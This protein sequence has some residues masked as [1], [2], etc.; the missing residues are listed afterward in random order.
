MVRISWFRFTLMP[1][2]STNRG[3]RTRS[4][5]LHCCQ[6][7][8]VCVGRREGKRA[9]GLESASGLERKLRQIQ[10]GDKH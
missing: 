7:G 9:S 4:R 8:G 5:M 3:P 6:D 2:R 1:S 10:G